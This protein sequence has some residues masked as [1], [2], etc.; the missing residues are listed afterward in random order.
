MSPTKILFLALL[1]C[2]PTACTT[3]ASSGGVV[4]TPGTPCNEATQHELCSGIVRMGCSGGVWQALQACDGGKLCIALPAAVGNATVCAQVTAGD[5]SGQDLAWPDVGLQDTSTIEPD[6]PATTADTGTDIATSDAPAGCFTSAQCDDGQPCTADSCSSGKC[7]HQFVSQSCNDGDGCTSNDTCK[8]GACIGTPLNCDDGLPCTADS[9]AQG[10]CKH[11]AISGCSDD[12]MSGATPL[13]EGKETSGNLSPTGDVDYYQFSGQKGQL[14]VVQIATAQTKQKKPMDTSI[15][16]TVMTMYGPDQQPYAFDDDPT[17]IF[18]NDSEIWTV[19]PADGTY[20]LRVEECATYLA[21]QPGAN[22]VCAAPTN[23]SDTSYGITFAVAGSFPTSAQDQEMGD[24]VSNPTAISF[25][26]TSDGKGYY[27]EAL[28]GTYKNGVDVDPFSFTPPS[29][30]PLTEGR[31]TLFVNGM[32][33]G[34]QGSGS[35]CDPGVAWL[36]VTGN[37]AK[38]A[39]IDLTKGGLEVPVKLGQK[40]ILAVQHGSG[41]KGNNDFYVLDASVSSSGPLESAE[42]A[43]DAL[44]GAEALTQSTNA[45]GNVSFFIAGDL[46]NGAQDIDHFSAAVPAGSWTSSVYCSA[47]G[48]GS[49]V[50]GLTAALVDALDQP[51]PGASGTEAAGPQQVKDYAVPAGTQKLLLKVT[52]SSQSPAQSGAFYRC[53]VVLVPAK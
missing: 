26:K 42:S 33:G 30:L 3:N 46:I 21:T 4:I 45:A 27:R 37:S 31:A 17:G 29:D 19:L 40:V 20:W 44:A 49:G 15:I 43:N 11:S 13:T 41:A 50:Q 12:T 47:A 9:C 28:W 16:D 7:T 48:I 38:V 25:L 10:A 6:V 34:V 39:Q 8:V 52:A 35:T 23:K 5:G 18:I 32:P 2:A 22:S 53:T 24:T 1:A 36:V 14:I 51:L